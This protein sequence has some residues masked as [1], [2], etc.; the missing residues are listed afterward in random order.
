M[1]NKNIHMIDSFWVKL[2]YSLSFRHMEKFVWK[3]ERDHI[4]LSPKCISIN[5]S[6]LYKLLG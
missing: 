3:Y 1:A 2:V 4:F 5:N 6:G